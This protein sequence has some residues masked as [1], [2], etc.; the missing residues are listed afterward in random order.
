MDG[1]IMALPKKR[2][3]EID[4]SLKQY[5]TNP[6][7]KGSGSVAARYRIRQS[8]NSA[9][10]KLLSKHRRSFRAIPYVYDNGDILFH[11]KIPSET[12][13]T[14]IL[15]DVIVFLPGDQ[16]TRKYENRFVRMWSNSPSFMFTYAYVYY[17]SN[18]MVDSFADKFPDIVLSDAPVVRNPLESLGFE[19]S[20]YI[21]GRYLIE[22]QCLTDSYIKRYGINATNSNIKSLIRF[23]P[24]PEAVVN[25]H[26]LLTKLER[27]KINK[28]KKKRDALKK[29]AK[30]DRE[31]KDLKRNKLKAS[32]K[33]SGAKKRPRSKITAKKAKKKL[34][35]RRK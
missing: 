31:R 26:Q 29:K 2:K 34:T 15:Y 12:H 25:R 1:D 7:G 11:V 33:I 3:N 22:G 10:V 23:T 13:G 20:T 27:A 16:A 24:N 17:H 30:L 8:L 5:V 18:L 14:E 32:R 21:A 19:K 35:T 28:E 9:F 6:T 4:I